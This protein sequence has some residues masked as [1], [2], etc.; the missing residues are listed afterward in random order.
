MMNP[1]FTGFDSHRTCYLF[2]N[3]W[4]VLCMCFVFVHMLC[5]SIMGKSVS[6]IT[7]FA[8]VDL[9]YVFVDSCMNVVIH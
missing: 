6:V 5:L 1:V 9:M 2:S 4:N 8:N 3:G 7:W